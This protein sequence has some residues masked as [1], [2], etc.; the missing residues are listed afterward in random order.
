MRGPERVVIAWPLEVQLCGC[1]K[2]GGVCVYCNFAA[3]E[4]VDVVV[5]GNEVVR[6]WRGSKGGEDGRGGGSEAVVE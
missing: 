2:E 6:P 3:G 4:H 1:V 5:R